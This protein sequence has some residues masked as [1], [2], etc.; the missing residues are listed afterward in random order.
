MTLQ[1]GNFDGLMIDNRYEYHYCMIA[2]IKSELNKSY[3]VQYTYFD[4]FFEL[5]KGYK[6]VVDALE[7]RTKWV[8][9]EGG[10]FRVENIEHIAP[11]VA[12]N[13]PSDEFDEGTYKNCLDFDTSES[14]VDAFD[15]RYNHTKHVPIDLIRAGE[16][17]VR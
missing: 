11:V 3:I 12:Y 6:T 17:W 9:T 10:V 13:V 16:R 7:G 15:G 4:S 14:N 2:Y 1:L 5:E 8:N